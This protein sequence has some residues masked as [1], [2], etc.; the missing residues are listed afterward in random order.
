MGDR[1]PRVQWGWLVMAYLYLSEECRGDNHGDCPGE[2]DT[3]TDPDVCG[4]GI[5]TC[6]CHRDYDEEEAERVREIADG[7][8]SV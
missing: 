8:E 3:P 5:C 1:A 4:G 6:G 7:L 2:R